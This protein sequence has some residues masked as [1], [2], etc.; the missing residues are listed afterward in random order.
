[1]KEDII[2]KIAVALMI[3]ICVGL[4]IWTFLSVVMIEAYWGI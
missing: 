2:L 3:I 1:M 4:F